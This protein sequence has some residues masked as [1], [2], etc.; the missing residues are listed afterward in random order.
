ML[1]ADC[2]ARIYSVPFKSIV[3]KILERQPKFCAVISVPSMG[4][5]NFSLSVREKVTCIYAGSGNSSSF[6]MTEVIRIKTEQ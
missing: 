3:F 4:N 2:K 5:C 1:E 6:I